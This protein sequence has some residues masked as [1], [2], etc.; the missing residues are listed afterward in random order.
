MAYVDPHTGTQCILWVDPAAKERAAKPL[1]KDK[2]LQAALLVITKAA[3]KE[4]GAIPKLPKKTA[5]AERDRTVAI[6]STASGAISVP[7]PHRFQGRRSRLEFHQLDAI[8]VRIGN[9][10]QDRLVPGRDNLTDRRATRFEHFS[11]RG[12]IVHL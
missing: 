7:P 12:H 3:L 9:E 11:S 10:G 2:T 4:M 8:A 1:Q 6:P 5:T